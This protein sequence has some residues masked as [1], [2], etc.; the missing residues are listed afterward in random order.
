MM[1]WS[2]PG[3]ACFVCA[4]IAWTCAS[5]A[6]DWNQWRGPARTGA[7]DAL[8]EVLTQ[9]PADGLLPV[10]MTQ[11]R[12][13]GGW[14][15]PIVAD[16][17]V[18]LYSHARKKREDVELEP[19]QYPQLTPEQQ[20]AMDP[21][22]FKAYEEK[23][24]DENFQRA[25]KQFTFFDNVHCFAADS[26]TLLWQ[27][28][29]PGTAVRWGQ[30]STPAAVEGT[31]Y[32]VGSDRQ[33]HALQLSDGT[34]T[35][36][37]PLGISQELELP[38]ASSVSIIDG[39]AILLAERLIGIDLAT[40]DLAWQKDSRQFGGVYSS[41]TAWDS[42][43]G[44]LAI[45]NVETRGG[46]TV[47]IRPRTGDEVWRLQTGASKSTPVVFEDRLV[48]YAGSRKGGLR[49]Y[50]LGAEMPELLWEYHRASDPGSSPLVHAGKV[51]ITG[52]K[53][54]ACVSMDDG[55]QLWTTE[56]D[57][58]QTR[59]SSP[60]AV[61]DSV[62][63]LFDGLWAFS[64]RAEDYLPTVEAK[65]GQ[66]GRLAPGQFYRQKLGMDELEK[67]A[68]GQVQAQQL[69]QEHVGRFGPLDCTSPAIV[70]GRIYI[71]LK[72]GLACYDLNS[73]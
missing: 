68:A 64:A 12:L 48:T 51:F 7:A 3:I 71:R 9:L 40:H 73:R 18:V 47:A 69:W 16:N 52:D 5:P 61:G 33:L 50:R 65:F 62:F 63:Y 26:G 45:I 25:K 34:P 30:S 60:V 22:E 13:Q 49:C 6:G 31:V 53:L 4:S 72:S 36:T 38:I 23:R 10:W 59:Y 42:P 11:D 55:R 43:A 54:L 24:F 39:M 46:E 56:L 17:K 32:V 1:R 58:A 70:D 41:A 19:P 28:E 2:A 66:Q 20:Q 67:S 27:R 37:T 44:P 29:W 57:L 21:D 15:S 14:S 8:S 35:W